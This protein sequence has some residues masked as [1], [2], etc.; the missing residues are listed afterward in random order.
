MPFVDMQGRLKEWFQTAFCYVLDVKMTAMKTLNTLAEIDAHIATHRLSL[1][2][3]VSRGCGICHAVEP[4][5]E[6]VLQTLPKIAAARADA[7]DLPELAGR[8]HVL[9]A[10][11]VML[12]ADGREVWRAAKFVYMNELEKTL[13][14]WAAEYGETV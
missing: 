1:L 14:L 12:F 9:T 10:P 11:V 8:F 13:A 7:A 3:V 4:K 6:R 2:Y 5:L